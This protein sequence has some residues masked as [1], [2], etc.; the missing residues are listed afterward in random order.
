MFY[1]LHNIDST[2]RVQSPICILTKFPLLQKLV[3]KSSKETRHSP[4]KQ[5]GELAFMSVAAFVVSSQATWSHVPGC[6]LSFSREDCT[7]PVTDKN[8]LLIDLL[9]NKDALCL[10][11]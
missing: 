4:D 2:K 3:C 9:D 5:R 8:E 1:K 10:C 11:T 7:L 6:C